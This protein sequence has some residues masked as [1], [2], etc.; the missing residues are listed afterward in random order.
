MRLVLFIILIA[1]KT[2][3]SQT[4][5][6]TIITNDDKQPAS[7]ATL[8]IKG[9]GFGTVADENGKFKLI[10][11][12]KYKDQT[13][14]V[15]F[16][17]YTTKTLKINELSL[18]SPNSI[19]LDRNVASLA[20]FTLKAHKEYKPKELLRKALK[21]IEDN[22]TQ[23]TITFDGYYRETLTENGKYIK[24]ADADCQFY[25]TPY[26]N[27]KHKR[28]E[29]TSSFSNSNSLS[30]LPAWWGARMHRGHFW[31]QTFIQ[32]Q[33]KIV[34]SRSSNNLST[35]SFKA[36]IEGG[37]LGLLAKDRV[38]FKEYFLDKKNFDE[39]DYSLEEKY[40]STNKEWSYYIYFISKKANETPPEEKD[41]WRIKKKFQENNQEG[42]LII[43]RNSFAI[44]S[45]EYSVNKNLKKFICGYRDNA[46]RHF[47]YQIKADYSL[48]NGR[49]YLTHLKQQDE[50][51]YNDTIENIRTPYNATLE[52]FID[53]I[54]SKNVQPFK[55]EEVFVNVDAN[56]LF[57]FPLY[58]NDTFWTKYS[59]EKPQYNIPN[60]IRIDMEEKH[61][62]ETQ[63]T[64]KHVRDTSLQAPIAEKKPYS[65]SIHNKTIKDDYAWLKDVKKPLY[66]KEVM[67][68]INAENDY[69]DNY[70]IP[71][72]KSQRLLF[73]ELKMYVEKNYESLPI[74]KNGYY[75]YYQYIDENEYPTFYRRN[76][77]TDEEELLL[78]VEEMAKDK[79]YYNAGNIDVSP[80]NTVMS[81]FENTTG[82]DDYTIKFKN[83]KTN[84]LLADS[85]I[86]PS[87]IL[88]INDS[89]I[90]YTLQEE[91]T[92]RPYKVLKHKL[93][94]NQLND[95]LIFHEMDELYNLSVSKSKSKEYVFISSS[96][97]N[98]SE[99]YFIKMNDTALAL[100]LF[101][102]REL[103]HEYYI[104]HVNDKF[105]VL[106]NH[107]APNKRLVVVDTADYAMKKWKEVVP[108]NNEV[109]INNFELFDNHIV[110]H[111]KEDA[112]P[113][114]RVINLTTQKDHIIKFKEDIYSVSI[115]YN[116]DFNTDTLQFSYSSFLTPNTI[117]N[118]NM[119]TQEKIIVKRR[120]WKENKYSPFKVERI[121]A[122]A[123]DG[124]KI[125]ITLFYSKWISSNKKD[126]EKNKVWLTSYGS[127]GAS[128]EVGFNTSL[129]PLLNR[130]FIYA[131]AHI[132]G[133]NDLGEE[134]YLD[135]KMLNK[136][137]TFTDFI[138]CSE[139]LIEKEY[140]TKGN[141]TIQGGS[142]GGLLM[143]AVANM[144]PDLYKAIVLDVPFVD[145]VNTMLDDKLPLTTGEYEEWGNPN[146]KKDYE[147]IKSY[148][149]YDNVTQQNYPPMFFFTGLNDSRVGYWEPAKMVAKLREYKTDNN[150]LLL[151]TNLHSGHG[152]DSGRY[153][154]YKDLAMK[155]AIIFE[156][157]K[158]SYLK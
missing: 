137:N 128:Q 105:Y 65:Y 47:D 142:A 79:Q 124:K 134:W 49:Y 61:P 52:V 130:G 97:S 113:R 125:P 156:L 146:K 102:P 135:G 94:D 99:Q 18:T 108:H 13:I 104:T 58:Y 51:I 147:Y 72:R 41:S 69:F 91:K 34:E 87:S 35:R 30:D 70:F 106:T 28:K 16:L 121:W 85:L 77:K 90:I 63:F 150:I 64:N 68:Y 131:I 86:K 136:K 157:Y 126:P 29:F 44:K 129:F 31:Y 53:N 43:D 40:D 151:K 140:V 81:Y 141:I 100:N 6:G 38:K 56:Q 42:I 149:P 17:G 21:S 67:E 74:L 78:D 8:L 20:Q 23:D 138:T 132:R 110:I 22:Y 15:S 123:K 39:F 122:T 27:E 133:G 76:A 103:N 32:D 11:P 50:F 66:N 114:L 111:E 88:W 115:G 119:E 112:Q 75:Y 109:F 25:Y 37:P 3:F 19:Y 80:N 154:S 145:V 118:Y 36:N 9:E 98:T 60:E 57:D 26:D 12:P 153:S 54:Q 152:G 139:Y 33:V 48:I 59:S 24:Y 158:N 96:S 107:K 155:Y 127:Y 116:P 4:I 2:V 45:I 89:I 92:N 82:N 10:V 71:L 55:N 62:L 117:Y 83:L 73:D 144:R 46:I 5:T 95:E 120:K 84:E 101:Y 7:F 143:G 93:N 14:L 148:S 1:T